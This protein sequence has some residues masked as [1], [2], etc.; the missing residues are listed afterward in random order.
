ML[1]IKAQ[2]LHTRSTECVVTLQI[3]TQKTY[4]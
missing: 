2:S 3:L 4:S 1:F